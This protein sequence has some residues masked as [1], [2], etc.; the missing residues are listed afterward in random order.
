MLILCIPVVKKFS[1]CYNFPMKKIFFLLL[2]AA[3][4]AVSCTKSEA[5]G[6]SDSDSSDSRAASESSR[7]IPAFSSTDLDGNSVT[8]EIFS[9]ADVSVLNVWGT[10]CPPCIAE[11]PELAAWSKEMGENV[12]LV[13]LVCD[14]ASVKNADGVVAAKE[15]LGG[16]GADFLNIVAGADLTP[17]LRGI[18]FVPSTFLIDRDG[19]IIG[20]MIVG[21]Q[22]QKYKDAVEAYLGK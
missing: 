20:D 11:M 6:K 17:F 7:A 19:N 2:V 12:Q 18:Q 9:R 4:L 1:F 5:K 13:G 10:F 15:I 3:L 14:V 21:A 22:V 8:N 16:A